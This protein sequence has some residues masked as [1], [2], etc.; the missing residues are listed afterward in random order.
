MS[1]LPANVVVDTSFMAAALDESAPEHEAAAVFLARLTQARTTIFFNDLVDLEMHDVAFALAARGPSAGGSGVDGTV[2]V[3]ARSMLA[4]WRAVL[5][6]AEAVHVDV[7]LTIDD[8]QYYM[9]Q[10]GLSAQ[11]AAHV[12][13]SFLSQAQRILTVDVDF[14]RVDERTLRI[15]T[16]ERLVRATRARR[17]CRAA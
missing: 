1:A 14:G 16:P 12:G 3:L 17:P 2:G 9:G 13:T 15:Y 4:R 8:L 6:H 5:A 11:Q 10:F 7:A